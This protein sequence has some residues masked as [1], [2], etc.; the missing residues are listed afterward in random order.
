M[1]ATSMSLGTSLELL[2][3]DSP[4][5]STEKHYSDTANLVDGLSTAELASAVE[6][7]LQNNKHLPVESR[8]THDLSV[9]KLKPTNNEQIWIRTKYVSHQD[10][11]RMNE[12]LQ[13]WRK[14]E[15]VEIAPWGCSYCF[16]L[17]YLSK[18]DAYGKKVNVRPCLDLRLLNQNLSD[19]SYPLPKFQDNINDAGS[20]SGQ[21]VPYSTNILTSDFAFLKRTE[22]GPPFSGKGSTS[23]L[24]VHQLESK[25]WRHSSKWSWTKYSETRSL[26]FAISMTSLVSLPTE[27]NELSM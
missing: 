3:A 16:P 20:L 27:S 14:T 2:A 8:C 10:E 7:A 11:F 9:F 12:K 15:V 24:H 23:A 21:D 13:V 17:L 25:L 22:I 19:I 1:S 6:E 18:K 5:L 26:R 4:A